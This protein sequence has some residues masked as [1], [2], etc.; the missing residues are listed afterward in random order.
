VR[1]WRWLAKV[2]HSSRAALWRIV[3]WKI[4]SGRSRS[5]TAV[6]GALPSASK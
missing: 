5:S 3:E 6:R 4:T 1:V 2:I